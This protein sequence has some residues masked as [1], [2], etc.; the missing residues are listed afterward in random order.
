MNAPIR[1]SAKEFRDGGA[2][3]IVLPFPPSSLTPHAKGYWRAKHAA[4]KAYRAL[5][6]QEAMAQGLRQVS[7]KAIR[8]RVTLHRPNLR[9]D[10]QNCISCF[11]AGVDGLADRIGVDDRYWKIDF[12]DGELDRPKGRVVVEIEVVNNG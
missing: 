4:T 2:L 10:Y 12:V 3:T 5:C 11:K 6:A 1:M 9:R 7:A 8:A